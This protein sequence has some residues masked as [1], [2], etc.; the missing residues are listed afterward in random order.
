M[1][2]KIKI[3]KWLKVVFF[4]TLLPMQLYAQQM[5]QAT[6]TLEEYSIKDSN[7]YNDLCS[8]LFSNTIFNI[9]SN[10]FFAMRYDTNAVH[11]GDETR[12]TFS[13]NF[14]VFNLMDGSTILHVTKNGKAVIGYFYI[15]NMPCFILNSTQHDFIL[16]YL[17]P[18]DKKKQFTFQNRY[19]E[20]GFTSVY[21]NVQPNG[22]IEV[23]RVFKCE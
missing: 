18:T 16:Q 14:L 12:D 11:I 5:E 22:K 23:V 13:A 8:V 7:F 20:G 17:I 1:Y 6:F 21:M 10:Y 3:H 15:K 9:R 19:S 2:N 4:S